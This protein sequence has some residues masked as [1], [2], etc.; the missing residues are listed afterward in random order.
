MTDSH[1]ITIT[2]YDVD[3]STLK[4]GAKAYVRNTTKKTSSAVGTTNPSGVVV[5]DLA[6]LPIGSG[7]TIEY[8]TGDE[9][10]IIAYAHTKYGDSHDCARYTVSGTSKSQTLY[11]NPIPH[12]GEFTS[13]RVKTILTGNTAGTVAYCKVYS[14]S[15]GELLAHIETPANSSF[16]YFA[17]NNGF[18]G[19]AWVIEREAQTLI[20][21]T[22]IK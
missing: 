12:Y 10:L 13:V 17:G 15:D 19:G 9:I 16:A 8:E 14:V 2:V 20:V 5:I 1:P 3:N 11:L 7:Q 6:D 21:T 18:G 22:V 4:S